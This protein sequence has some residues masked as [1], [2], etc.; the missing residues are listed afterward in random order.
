MVGPGAR[1]T[2]GRVYNVDE[3]DEDLEMD[4]EGSNSSSEDFFSTD[5]DDCPPHPMN[6]RR[7]RR[8][9]TPSEPQRFSL[10]LPDHP[11]AAHTLLLPALDRVCGKIKKRLERG[12][13]VLVCLL[14]GISRSA[15]LVIAYI[16][17]EHHLSYDQAFHFV[18]PATHA[19][20][21][22]AQAPAAARFPSGGPSTA[23]VPGM[24][25][26]LP[27]GAPPLMSR[28]TLSGAPPM[29]LTLPPGRRQGPSMSGGGPSMPP[30][31]G[32]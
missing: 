29:N 13:S 20:P 15:S 11:S 16:M 10:P 2:A 18:K 21:V 14:Q 31:R 17:R 19:P 30:R 32:A 28:P 7:R 5:D 25:P 23:P 9:S 4:E 8:S 1:G 6:R 27:L 24:K 26:P 3:E 22:F 12:V